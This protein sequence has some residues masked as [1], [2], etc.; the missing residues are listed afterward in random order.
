MKVCVIGGAGRMGSWFARYFRDRGHEVSIL[1]LDEDRSEKVSLELRVRLVRDI[2]GTEAD[3]YFVCVPTSAVTEVLSKIN[4]EVVNTRATIVEISSV[5]SPLM[6]A[7]R[8]S[9]GRGFS[10]LSIHP[11]FGPGA[12][13]PSKSPTVLV[14]L[15]GDGSEVALARGLMPDFNFLVMSADEHDRLTSFS[16]SLTHFVNMAF[17]LSICE[18]DLSRLKEVAG[19]S[20]NSQ[21]RTLG[22]VLDGG[23]AAVADTLIL[24]SK[25]VYAIERFLEVSRHLLALVRGGYAKDLEKEV[26]LCKLVLSSLNF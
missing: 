21:I 23:D 15:A 16:L 9:L 8:E 5:K 10:V 4:R 22:H 7:L 3:V 18:E 17:C 6:S 1:D 14:S 20:F 26:A 24:N 2:R 11:M 25:S 13:D 12:G 19:A